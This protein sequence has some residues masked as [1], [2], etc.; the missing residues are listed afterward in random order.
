MCIRDSQEGGAIR[1]R[2]KCPAMDSTATQ[3]C[4]KALD[5]KRKSKH[6][7]AH[8]KKGSSTLKR[9]ATA[10]SGVSSVSRRPAAA[11]AS[12]HGAAEAADVSSDH[13]ERSNATRDRAKARKFR[14]MLKDGQLPAC[15]CR[16]YNELEAKKRVRGFPY[17]TK[18]T[19]L[20]DA[21][22]LRDTEKG[23]FRIDQSSTFCLNIAA[24]H[25]R[26]YV[27]D[28]YDVLVWEEAAAILGGDMK[29]L[30]ALDL[31]LIHI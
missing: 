14:K 9:P 11:T 7:V 8:V 12:I 4:L 30:D 6:K 21:T 19:E 17:R 20:I 29:L 5:N 13:S 27:T 3:V 31:S 10:C 25:T 24:K 26:Q 16:E 2:G 22:L 28:K 18:L 15:I 23:N 1:R